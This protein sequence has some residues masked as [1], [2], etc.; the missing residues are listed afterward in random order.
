LLARV[1]RRLGRLVTAGR[2]PE[3]LHA[4]LMQRDLALRSEVQECLRAYPALRD[5]LDI[6]KC[7]LFLRRFGSDEV[8]PYA[9]GELFGSL[10]M[11]CLSYRCLPGR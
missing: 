8:V 4:S 5:L 10:A 6:G 3:Q 2:R 1:G 9:H 7:D 11:M